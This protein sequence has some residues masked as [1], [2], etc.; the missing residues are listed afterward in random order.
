MLLGRL[1]LGVL[2]LASVAPPVRA[3]SEEQLRAYFEGKSVRVRMEMPG[4]SQ[5]VDVYPGTRQ[6]I[7]YPQLAERLKQYGTAFRRGDEAMI[8]KIRVKKEL[9]EFQL[10]GGGF[11]TFGDDDSPYVS[12]PSAAKTTREKNLEREVESTTDPAQKRKLR[13][14]L[15]GLRR[16]REREDARNRTEA[17]Q[18]S[19]VKEANIR[20]RRLEGGSRF[21]LR[22]RPA[23]PFDALTPE[24]IMRALA[25]YLDFSIALDDRRPVPQSNR[26]ELRKGLTV[27]EVDALLGRPETI[28]RRQEGTLTVS[29]SIYRAKDRLVTAE[30]VEGVLIRFTIS[31]P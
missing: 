27:E 17:A 13:E 16:A 7:D 19:Q 28:D 10:G 25:D 29:T 4:T 11:G 24:S 30:F 5:G 21:N 31:S 14:E 15:D 20:Q 8:T 2:L 18:A 3:Q 1:S 26:D 9:I 22:Y 23:V 12:V 6:P